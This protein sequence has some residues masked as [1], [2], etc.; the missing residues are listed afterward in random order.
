MTVRAGDVMIR[1]VVAVHKH[2]YKDI[3]GVI[4]CHHDSALPVVDDHDRVV[5]VVSAGDLLLN[6][7]YADRPSGL[8]RL[9]LRRP[10][11]AKAA[12]LTPLGDDQ[13]GSHRHAGSDRG[14]RGAGHA[15]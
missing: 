3:I 10:E 13:H 1:K 6:E 7:A 12:A 5:G 4:C 8:P 2:Q 11:R 15:R 14:H 9:L